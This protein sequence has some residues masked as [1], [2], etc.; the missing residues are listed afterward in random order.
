MQRT[1]HPR[2]RYGFD[3][4]TPPPNRPTWESLPEAVTQ[5]VTVLL[6][7]MLCAQRDPE[8]LSAHPKEAD[9]E[10]ED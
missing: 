5:N 4:F 2:T 8:P 9:D 1:R 3:L 10:R 6:A 7:A